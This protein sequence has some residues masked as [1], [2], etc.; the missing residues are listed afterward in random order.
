M[1]LERLEIERFYDQRAPS[2]KHRGQRVP[3][4]SHTTQRVLRGLYLS[5]I[6]LIPLATDDNSRME[7]DTITSHEKM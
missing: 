2:D 3:Y 6:D 7:R 4:E 1:K 5:R